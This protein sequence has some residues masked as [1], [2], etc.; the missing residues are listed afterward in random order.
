MKVLIVTNM[1]PNPDQ[2]AFGTFVYD[3]VEALRQA[4]IEV[5]VLFINGRKSRLNYLWGVFRFW[6]AVFRK[7][8][9]IVHAHYA[10][11]GF[12]ARL[13]F[14]Y[15]VVVTYHGAEVLDHVPRWLS[16]LAR[17]GPRMF[18]RIIVVNKREKDRII[19]GEARVV[20][21]PGGINLDE[22]FPI[23]TAE[24]RT[25]LGLPIDR[26]LVLWAGEHWQYEKRFELVKESLEV[27]KQH[28]PEAE[29]VLVSG[30]PHAVIPLYM[31]A[32][33]ALLLTSRS[34]GSPTVIKEAMACNLPIVSTDVGD[35][36]QVI[37]GVEGCYLV[38]P[39]AKD[40]AD[41]LLQ[42]LQ[43]R[44]RTNGR[45][46]IEHL[47]SGPITQRII[48]VYNEVCYPKRQF[49]L[50]SATSDPQEYRKNKGC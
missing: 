11:S 31:S 14:L 40:I 47:G 12:V 41:K 21:I 43:W 13:Q 7:R 26:P 49:G 20:V 10:I 45:N 4:G 8:Y 1:Y 37:A 24:A 6:G 29:L 35:V 28:C 33:D 22:F 42:V 16:F 48:A 36:A 39:M 27:L 23:P 46:K 32:C 17:R 15:P 9:D 34:E 25:L 18:D 5:D 3:Q 2:P 50:N 44:Q 38:E 19:N 30:K